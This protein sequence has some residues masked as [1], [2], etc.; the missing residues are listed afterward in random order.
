MKENIPILTADLQGYK[1]LDSGNKKKLEEVHGIRMVRSEPRA[2]WKPKLSED[3]WSKVE[4]LFEQEKGKWVFKNGEP[5]DLTLKSHSV[6]FKLK[7]P[8]TSKHFGV[9]PEQESQWKFIEEKVKASNKPKILNLFGY[10]GG[11]SLVAASSGA[12]VVHIDGS[13]AVIAWARENQEASGLESAQ[14]RWILEDAIDFVKREAKRGNK[15]DGIIMDPP[16]YGRGPKGQIWKIEEDLVPFLKAC[17]EILVDKPLFVILNM[18]STELS[19]L[20]LKN[21]V[22]DMMEGV[23]GEVEAGELTLQEEGGR[24]LPL[25]IFA[26]FGSK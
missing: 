18:Y 9:F 17:R 24:V 7:F 5:E 11:A 19:A 3:E 2:W 22:E 23:S 1:L 13:R 6:T 10:T 25:S 8:G 12:E 20:N 16:S 15:Y 4:A 26:R 21:L 14:I